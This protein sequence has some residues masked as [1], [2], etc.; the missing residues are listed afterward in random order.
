[1]PQPSRFLL[2]PGIRRVGPIPAP[3]Q[4]PWATALGRLAGSIDAAR[5]GPNPIGAIEGRRVQDQAMRLDRFG[6]LSWP[7]DH[8]AR[9]PPDP[10]P[11]SAVKPRRAQGTALLRVGERVV[12]RPTQRLAGSV[13]TAGGSHPIPFR[14]RP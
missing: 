12:A 5:S 10:I 14:T 9:A 7:G 4:P 2:R 8:S 6:P 13:I 11:N 3:C 1:M